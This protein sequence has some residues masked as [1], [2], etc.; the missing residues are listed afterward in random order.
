MASGKTSKMLDIIHR[1]SNIHKQRVLLINFTG[2]CRSGENSPGVSTHRYG[3]SS[4]K[5][6]IGTY[7]VP[8]KVSRLGEITE[9]LVDTYDMIGIDEA[10]FYPDLSEFV[11]KY[12]QKKIMFHISGLSYDSDNKPFGQLLDIIDVCTT[13]EKM[14]A[15]CSRC[16]PKNMIPAGFTYANV[17]KESVVAVGGLDMYEPLCLEHYLELTSK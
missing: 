1:Y 3:D 14:A 11:H 15:V 7:I 8:I 10:Q 6:P 5:I 2:D 9:E 4:M 16:D 17:K 13:Y 12:K